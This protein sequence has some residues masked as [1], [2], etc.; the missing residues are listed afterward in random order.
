MVHTVTTKFGSLTAVS[1]HAVS[2][3]RTLGTGF[4]TIRITVINRFEMNLNRRNWVCNR[5]TV[6]G[7]RC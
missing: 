5:V 7:I 3:L 1:R 6:E 2:R 4:G